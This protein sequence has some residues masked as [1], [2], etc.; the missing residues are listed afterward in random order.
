MSDFCTNTK[1]GRTQFWNTRALNRLLPKPGSVAILPEAQDFRYNVPARKKMQG[2]LDVG[3]RKVSRN[4]VLRHRFNRARASL[5]FALVCTLSWLYRN[6][7]AKCG[8]D[9]LFKKL[10]ASSRRRLFSCWRQ[11]IDYLQDVEKRE[12]PQKQLTKLEVCEK[13]SGLAMA[14]TSRKGLCHA[15]L[16]FFTPDCWRIVGEDEF[17]ALSKAAAGAFYRIFPDFKKDG[18]ICLICFQYNSPSDEQV[19]FLHC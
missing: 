11:S 9:A 16:E 13:R 5:D 14:M 17:A 8:E 4:P 10:F 7:A 6:Q 19:V 15:Q 18:K 2:I 12:L 1:G 3:Q